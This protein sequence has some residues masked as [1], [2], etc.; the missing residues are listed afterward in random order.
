MSCPTS[1][2]L[3]AGQMN[4]NMMMEAENILKKVMNKAKESPA[5]ASDQEECKNFIDHIKEGKT[6]LG[7]IYRI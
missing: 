2:N 3:I 5:A 6:T 4:L 7:K 1:N